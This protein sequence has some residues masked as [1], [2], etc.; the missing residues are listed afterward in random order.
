[1]SSLTTA[2]PS[3]R[4]A[5]APQRNLF[6]LYF[7]EAKLEF[8]KLLRLPAYSVAVL[9][10]PVMFYVIFGAIFGRFDVQGISTAKYMVVGYSAAGVLAAS[11]FGFGVGVATERGQGWLR[12][13]RVSPMP[14]LAY[15]VAKIAMAFLFSSIVV[16]ILSVLGAAVQGV[17]FGFGDWLTMYG[18]LMLG[19]L[20]F[21]SL[22]LAFGYLFGPNSAPMILNLIYTPAAFL[23][24]LWIPL[25]VLPP[26]LQKVATFLPTYHYA[27][28]ALSG[29]GA[30][31]IGSPLVHV[32]VL[33][34]STA[35]FLALAVWAY[36]RDDGKTFG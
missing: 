19:V 21:A 3:A 6:R 26:F 5:D 11:L 20:P 27:Q 12:L 36:I 32:V 9:A 25:A 4:R 8:L 29:A 13:K 10:F 14:P 7:T 34:G 33:A 31:A 16:V 1:M 2:T 15:F 23:S 18:L 24:G 35:L 30:D 17:R 28:L 22:G